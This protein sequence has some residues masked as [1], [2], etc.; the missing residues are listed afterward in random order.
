M[1]RRIYLGLISCL[2]AWPVMAAELGVL[3]PN[4]KPLARLSDQSG[5]G[6]FLTTLPSIAPHAYRSG[7]MVSIPVSLEKL[8]CCDENGGRLTLLSLSGRKE[9]FADSD[10]QGLSRLDLVFDPGS[11]SLELYPTVR[12]IV[13]GRRLKSAFSYSY[14]LPDQFASQGQFCQVNPGLS[15]WK[16]NIYFNAY[17]MVV[18]AVPM[19]TSLAPVYLSPVNIGVGDQIWSD[20]LNYPD[21]VVWYGRFGPA[22]QLAFT[23]ENRIA[24]IFGVYWQDDTNIPDSKIYNVKD[25]QN[26]TYGSRAFPVKSPLLDA[27]EGAAATLISI[28][29]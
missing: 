4:Q 26:Y 24:Q 3:E 16:F 2:A 23:S 19:G 15:A 20:L 27:S 22:S 21:E 10:I 18:E 9:G 17:N 28:V 6:Y 8:A 13:A 5:K 25:R 12:P 14:K 29:P 11:G 7:V 1:M